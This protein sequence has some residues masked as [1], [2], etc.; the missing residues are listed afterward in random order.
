MRFQLNACGI[1]FCPQYLA[2]SRT[3]QP[4]AFLGGVQMVSALV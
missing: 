2:R 1:A 4:S 3:A